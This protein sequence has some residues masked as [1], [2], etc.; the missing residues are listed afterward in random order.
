MGCMCSSAPAEDTLREQY[1]RR[2]TRLIDEALKNDNTTANK[3]IKLLLLGTG[4]SGKSTLLKQIVH[5]HGPGFSE[6]KRAAYLPIVFANVLAGVMTMLRMSDRLPDELKCQVTGEEELASKH[7]LLHDVTTNDEIT[8]SLAA[9]IKRL[10]E[11]PGIQNTYEHRSRFQLTDSIKY[12]LDKIDE[13]AQPQYVPSFDDILHVRARTTGIVQQNIMIDNNQFLIIDVGGQRNERKK[14]IHCFE[15]V[16]AVIYV[17]AINEYDQVLY[18]DQH[19]NRLI[20]S[21][22]LFDEVCN[23]RWFRDTAM[24]IFLNKADLFQEKLVNAGA[25]LNRLFPDYS[26]GADFDAATDF[27][28]NKFLEQNR[29]GYISEIYAH[30]TT[31]TD[32]NNIRFTFNAVKDIV[33]KKR[34]REC[35]LM[36]E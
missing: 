31:A 29:N 16:T 36:P 33:I 8:P 34:L 26:G 5:L 6:G 24:I 1:E 20:E 22:E 4:E 25:S 9:H 19:S 21:L 2:I 7:K 3:E 28:V 14:W 13:I 35:G 18:E 32:T 15:N 27:I 10:W 23:S 30:V 12:F 11:S 17:A